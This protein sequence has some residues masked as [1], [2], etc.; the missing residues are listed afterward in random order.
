MHQ[1][2]QIIALCGAKRAGKDTLANMISC[3]Y[4]YQ[5]IKI[6]H[7]LK[8][9]CKILFNFTDEQL[10]CDSKE[11]VDKYWKISPRQAMQFIGTDIMQFQIQ[12]I[13]P[14]VDR[15]FWI[16]TVLNE[17]DANPT[18]RYVISDLRFHHE[19]DELKKRNAIIIKI[20][21]PSMENNDM[22]ISEREYINIVPD[23]VVKNLGD[24]T[25]DLLSQIESFFGH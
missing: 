9:V 23:I 7:K 11:N 22:H 6:S 13:M 10:E 15:G 8:Q 20:E 18:S 21:R 3:K 19:V 2:P 17:I 25:N 4:G 16:K 5:H 14:H 24:G 1:L 12:K